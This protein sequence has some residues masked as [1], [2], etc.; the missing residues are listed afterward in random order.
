V[1]DD[2]EHSLDNPDDSGP[3]DVAEQHLARAGRVGLAG[4]T[5]FYLLLVGL[6]VRVALLDGGGTSDNGVGQMDAAGALTTIDQSVLGEVAIGAVAAGFLLFGVARLVGAVRDHTVSLTRRAMTVFQGLFYL[7]LAWVPAAFLA[8]NRDTGS[9]QQQVRTVGEVLRRP[10]GA[11]LLAVAGVVVIIV[12]VQQIRTGINRQFIEGLDLSC[13]PKA[14]CRFCDI[15]GVVGIAARACVFMPVG[16]FLIVAAAKSDPGSAWG[17]DG[18]L[19]A[20]T[21]SP[22]GQLVLVLVAAGLAI[23]AA[24]SCIEVRYRRVVCAR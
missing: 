7:V 18:E 19:M 17:T 2:R 15:A 14:V 23:F 22:W 20:L 12:C 4:R 24:F 21:G 16:V 6:T 1:D 3:I 8:G 9:Q 5:G 10:A 11:E 13:A